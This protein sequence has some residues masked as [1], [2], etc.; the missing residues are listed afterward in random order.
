MIFELLTIAIAAFFFGSLPVAKWVVFALTWRGLLFGKRYGALIRV[1]TDIS[2]GA[3]AV[4][5]GHEAGLQGAQLAVFFVYL[6]H[7]FPLGASFGKQNGTG[8]LLGALIILDPVIGLTALSSWMFAYYIYRHA[9]YSAVI[10]AGLTTLIC[11]FTGVTQEIRIE[12][13]F[14]L[15]AIVI[16]RHRKYLYVGL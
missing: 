12:M 16:W 9:S 1:I 3:A 10:S 6:G 2:K 11:S 7:I 15:T 5:F 13:L 8:T 4:S 14:I